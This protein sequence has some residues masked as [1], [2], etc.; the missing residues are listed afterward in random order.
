VLNAN[1][2]IKALNGEINPHNL[3][4]NVSLVSLQIF[5]DSSPAYSGAAMAAGVPNPL[6]PS[7]RNANDQPINNVCPK[8][9]SQRFLSTI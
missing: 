6:T 1:A 8:R 4:T 3:Q 2:T 9:L 7:I 5:G